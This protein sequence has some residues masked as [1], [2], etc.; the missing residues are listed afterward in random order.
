MSDES[1]LEYM[2]DSGMAWLAVSSEGG[3]ANAIA[4]HY[5][6]RW[7]PTLV[8]IDSAANVI[9]LNGRGEVA[10]NGAAAYDRWWAQTTG[11]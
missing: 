4:Q 5:D 11:G 9:S 1:L 6:V 8:V 3:R 2:M 7:V 10:A